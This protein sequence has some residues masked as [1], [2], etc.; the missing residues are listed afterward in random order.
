MEESICE[1]TQNDNVFEFK[2]NCL[3]DGHLKTISLLILII[4]SIIDSYSENSYFSYFS[5]TLLRYIGTW[6]SFSLIL[7]FYILGR[8]FY[9]KTPFKFRYVFITTLIKYLPIFFAVLFVVVPVSSYLM[10]DLPNWVLIDRVFDDNIGLFS[11]YRLYFGFIR[12]TIIRNFVKS[13]LLNKVIFWLA[14]PMIKITLFPF[15]ISILCSSHKIKMMNHEGVTE[16]DELNSFGNNSQTKLCYNNVELESNGLVRKESYIMELYHDLDQNN[17]I[18]IRFR[19]FTLLFTFILFTLTHSFI[20][21]LN[22]GR[23]FQITHQLKLCWVFIFCLSLFGILDIITSLMNNYKLALT[24]HG[25]IGFF[26]FVT[27]CLFTYDMDNLIAKYYSF[28]CFFLLGIW[29]S[30]LEFITGKGVLHHFR[31]STLIKYFLLSIF[32]Y[33]VATGSKLLWLYDVHYNSNLTPRLKILGSLGMAISI[34]Y[35]SIKKT[36]LFKKKFQWIYRLRSRYTMDP[37]ISC[38]L[39][40]I[41]SKK[42]FWKILKKD[43]FML[44][45]FV[46]ITTTAITYVLTEELLFGAF[47]SF[48]TVLFV[49]PILTLFVMNIPQ[50]FSHIYTLYMEE[51]SL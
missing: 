12:T 28:S 44:L 47:E 11:F 2:V 49:S 48:F 45:S 30:S 18:S 17:S 41:P 35:L 14:I 21:V 1:E 10:P 22:L 38:F 51:R 42:T 33:S 25:F 29:D 20:M 3:T 24:L 36:I 9:F 6:L 43:S 27:P 5:Q 13:K 40:L 50:I 46:P 39:N 31:F 37:S 26:L 7:F 15:I 23:A 32:I 34:Y 19:F 4:I 16:S 8:S